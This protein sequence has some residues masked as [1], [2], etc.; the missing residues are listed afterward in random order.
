MD[1]EKK[2]KNKNKEPPLKD[3]LAAK[4]SCRVQKK[5]KKGSDAMRW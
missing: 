2:K 4:R 1:I 5:G 3:T